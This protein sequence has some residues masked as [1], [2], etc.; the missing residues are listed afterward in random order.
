MVGGWGAHRSDAVDGGA[1]VSA[2]VR[3]RVRVEG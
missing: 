1:K 3:L 2:R